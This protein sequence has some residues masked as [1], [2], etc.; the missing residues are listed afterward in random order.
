MDEPKAYLQR[1]VIREKQILYINTYIW[2]LERCYWWNYLQ[3]SNG[4]EDM[5]IRLVDT[6]EE[7][8]GG[9][10]WESSMETYILPYVK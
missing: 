6:L 9:I 7:E 8:E 1:E 3:G 4:N 2:N 10:N 5:E